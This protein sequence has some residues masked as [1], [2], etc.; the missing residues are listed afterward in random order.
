MQSATLSP[1]TVTAASPTH[2]ARNSLM[3]DTFSKH[4]LWPVTV[5]LGTKKAAQL[6]TRSLI[7]KQNVWCI[8]IAITRETYIL[9]ILSQ[10]R[11]PRGPERYWNNNDVCCKHD[12]SF[13]LKVTVKGVFY[14]SLKWNWIQGWMA[15]RWWRPLPH[16]LSVSAWQMLR[17][18][19]G[20][21][22]SSLPWLTKTG[23]LH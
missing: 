13:I 5:K 8:F 18:L 2:A 16:S 21:N 7:N 9:L 14:T 23:D 10:Q 15:S 22:L 20:K 1:S 17:L 19:P 11:P 12:Y 4:Q 3:T 6:A